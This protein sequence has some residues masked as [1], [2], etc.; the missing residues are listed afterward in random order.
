MREARAGTTGVPPP[1]MGPPR[2]GREMDSASAMLDGPCPG[3][4]LVRRT[5]NRQ[6]GPAPEGCGSGKSTSLMTA[7]R[8]FEDLRVPC[9]VARPRYR[10]S[11]G[12][13]VDRAWAMGAQCPRGRSP[14]GG[15]PSNGH[16]TLSATGSSGPYRRGISCDRN[17]IRGRLGAGT[18]SWARPLLEMLGHRL[19]L[20]RR[21]L[22][23]NQ[24]GGLGL[25]GSNHLAHVAG[26]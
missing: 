2:A 11:A 7:G 4:H 18:A 10:P 9:G 16:A 24:P 17:R 15:D 8:R 22:L 12:F 14:L 26:L 20:G 25:P 23:T 21:L 1:R 3:G 5:W 6:P 19:R 13:G